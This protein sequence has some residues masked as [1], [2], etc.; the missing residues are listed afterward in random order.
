[1][2]F[3]PS[4]AVAPCS[5]LL[6]LSGEGQVT[7]P[8]CCLCVSLLLTGFQSLL[9]LTSPLLDK[10]SPQDNIPGRWSLLPA[11]FSTALSSTALYGQFHVSA[12]LR[13]LQ[14][15]N[16]LS[17]MFLFGQSSSTLSVAFQT[18]KMSPPPASL[19]GPPAWVCLVAVCL[20]A[21]PIVP[22]AQCLRQSRDCSSELIK[23]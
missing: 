5:S 10:P 18:T 4:V 19:P 8:D 23:N 7:L 9:P 12:N 16:W 13:Y 15:H 2:S 17:G 1:M 6:S 3:A 21:F 14:L 22:L 11:G 20:T